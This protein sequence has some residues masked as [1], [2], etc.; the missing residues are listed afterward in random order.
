MKKL[1]FLAV[2]VF[3]F[4]LP[5]AAYQEPGNLKLSLWDD[6]AFAIPN[7]IHNVEGLDLGIGSKT[8]K[9]TG[10]QWDILWANSS[11]LTGLSWAWG[12][13][14]TNRGTGAQMALVTLNDHM[15]GAQLGAVN[16]SW[17]SLTGAQVGFYNQAREIVGAQVGLINYAK[18]IHGLQVGLF[19]IA[20]NGYLPAMIFINGRF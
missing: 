16:V 6:I 9:M 14:K 2:L 5:A 10:L 8:Y 19:N 15:T 18:Y 17:R 12:A 11:Y 4:T 20:E 1:L 7:N 3:G 13:S